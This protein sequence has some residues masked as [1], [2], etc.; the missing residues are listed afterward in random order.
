M[1]TTMIKKTGA[2]LL[3]AILLAS[4]PLLTAFAKPAAAPANDIGLEAAKTKALAH[5][6]APANEAEI[7]K[8]KLDYDD[9]AAEYE[10]KFVWKDTRYSYEIDASSGAILEHSQ[11][12]VAKKQTDSPGVKVPAV[13]NAKDIGLEKAKEIAL[14]HAGYETDKVTFTE[15]KLDH[16]D[17]VA[18]YEIEFYADGKEYEYDIHSV[19]GEILDF[20]VEKEAR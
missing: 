3:A 4:L 14:K 9:G 12:A 16:D 18:E 11:K 17:G 5:A 1:K 8:A 19:T 13:G 2:L 15:A 6:G 7:K 20:E 10:I